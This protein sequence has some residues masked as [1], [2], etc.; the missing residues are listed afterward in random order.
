[1]GVPFLAH[2]IIGILGIA[3][4]TINYVTYRRIPRR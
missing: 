2:S 1:M 3:T 4:C